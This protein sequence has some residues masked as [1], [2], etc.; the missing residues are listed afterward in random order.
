MASSVMWKCYRRPHVL[1]HHVN[2]VLEAMALC[3][4]TALWI[5][6]GAVGLHM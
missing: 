4:D 2:F 1:F 6:A 3:A 5:S